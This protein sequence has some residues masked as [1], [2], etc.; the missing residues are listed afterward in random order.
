MKGS[1]KYNQQTSNERILITNPWQ[2]RQKLISFLEG[3]HHEEKMNEKRKIN[4]F[5]PELGMTPIKEI[6]TNRESEGDDESPH[7]LR[8]REIIMKITV[9][10]K[11][12]IHNFT[13]ELGMIPSKEKSTNREIEGHDYKLGMTPSKEKS[14]N[15]ESEGDDESKSHNLKWREIITPE[16]GMTSIVKEKSMNSESDGDDESKP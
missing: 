8:V 6:S 3:Y 2:R 13:P 12:K 14:T 9:N 7:N 1:S 4:N 11:R 15:S 16:L 5:T 10:E